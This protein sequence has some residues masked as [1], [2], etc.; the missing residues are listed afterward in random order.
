VP[1]DSDLAYPKQRGACSPCAKNRRTTRGPASRRLSSRTPRRS[2]RPPPQRSP[3]PGAGCT[4]QPHRHLLP[5]PRPLTVLGALRSGS[6]GR[7]PSFASPRL[8][9]RRRLRRA[10][11]QA[12]AHPPRSRSTRGPR[13]SR[14]AGSWGPWRFLRT[15]PLIKA[16]R[17]RLSELSSPGLYQRLRLPVTRSSAV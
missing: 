7:P 13:L 14:R 2:H 10:S 4:S 6:F 8:R 17:P 16:P 11:P 9:A 3:Q 15:L 1:S 5:P 12:S